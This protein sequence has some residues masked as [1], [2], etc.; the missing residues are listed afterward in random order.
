MKIILR[1]NVD[2]LGKIG[3][4]V[5]VKDGY[6]RNYLIPRGYAYLAKEGAIKRIEIE[7]KQYLK[8]VEKTK[9]DAKLLAAKISDTQ[10][11]VK[12]KVGEDSKLYGSVTNQMIAEELAAKGFDIDKRYILI[13]DT[14]KTLGIFDVK[15]KLHSEVMTSI[16]VW[17]IDE[18][19][20]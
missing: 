14:I 4:I 10:I 15:V 20:Q 5:N 6:A 9:E 16:K 13:E 17:V 18:K 3:D 12:M 8:Q 19:E 7:K 2:N 1:K 11:T